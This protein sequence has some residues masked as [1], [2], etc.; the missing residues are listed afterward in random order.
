MTDSA[1]YE[2]HVRSGRRH[3]ATARR[4]LRA[5]FPGTHRIQT[6]DGLKDPELHSPEHKVVAQ[7]YRQV[8]RFINLMS[9]EVGRS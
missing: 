1:S 2:L 9:L 3:V 8:K 6:V 4:F 7:G 5:P